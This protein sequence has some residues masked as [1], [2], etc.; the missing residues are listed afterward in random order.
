MTATPYLVPKRGILPPWGRFDGL[1]IYPCIFLRAPW[2]QTTLRHELI[3][4]HQ[5]CQVGW[6]QFY[7]G[8][9]WEWR[10]GIRAIGGTP[11]EELSAEVE[12]Y[13]HQSDPSF[14]PPELEQLVERVS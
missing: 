11:Y 9:L 3:H 12:A 10:L 2:T 6:L 13:S 7:A 8:Y 5:V 1:T 4:C 14:L